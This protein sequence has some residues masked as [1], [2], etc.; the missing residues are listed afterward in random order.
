M[1]GYPADARSVS[2]A[3]VLDGALPYIAITVQGESGQVVQTR[4]LIGLP[5]PV[6]GGFFAPGAPLGPPAYPANCLAFSD[7]SP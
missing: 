2:T 5:I 4:C 7:E 1:A 3:V 6:V